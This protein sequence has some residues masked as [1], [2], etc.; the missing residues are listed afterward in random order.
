MSTGEIPF[1]DLV[2]A[3]RE[4]REELRSVFETAL[5]SAAFV[6]GQVVQEFERDFAE[7]CESQFCVGMA[8]GTDALRLALVAAGVQSGDTVVTVPLTFIAT[9]EAISQAGA[10][11]DFVDIDERTYTMDPEKLRAYLETECTPNP[12][13]GRVVSKGTGGPVTA[14]HP[15]HLFGQMGEQEPILA[16]RGPYDPVRL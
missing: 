11:P 1:L 15:V 7:F 14:V 6:G 3:H 16:P 2:T 13:T 4:L 5:D 12:E 9:T 10:R 8:S